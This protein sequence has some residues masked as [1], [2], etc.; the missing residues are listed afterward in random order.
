MSGTIEDDDPM[1]DYHRSSSTAQPTGGG[2]DPM[3]PTPGPPK[4]VTETSW[5]SLPSKD[6]VGKAVEETGH[7]FGVGVRDVVQGRI[8]GLADL[9]TSPFRGA[10]NYVSPGAAT[11]PSEL[12]DKAGGLLPPWLYSKPQ[13]ER[14]KAISPI[15]QA[16]ASMIPL[17]PP[18]ARGPAPGPQAPPSLVNRT[19]IAPTGNASL[20]RAAGTV[21]AAGAG[22]AAG[23]VA[24][25]AIPE[26]SPW[27]VLKPLARLGGNVIGA[28]LANVSM[29]GIERV[30]NSALGKLNATAQA[31]ND[32]NIKPP[33]VGT[34]TG[35]PGV[36][37]L[38]VTASQVPG[39][40]GRMRGGMQETLD[41]FGNRIDEG[42][43]SLHFDATGRSGV[44]P[45]ASQTGEVVQD[46]IRNWRWNDQ[47]PHSF[48]SQE[49]KLFAPVDSRMGH[50]TVDLSGYR[51]ALSS[52]ALDA[53][54]RGLPATQ[55]A[56]AR[57]QLQTLLEALETDRPGASPT[58]RWE[59]AQALRR[60]IGDMR[61]TPEFQQGI[62]DAALSRIYAGIA[63]DM[64]AAATNNGVGRLYK[65]ANQ[66]ATEGHN[67]INRTAS[68]AVET[69]NPRQDIG[70]SQATD[71]LLDS[72]GDDIAQLRRHVPEAAD[73]LAAYK[74]RSMANAKPGQAT[75]PGETSA[76][77]FQTNLIKLKDE[78]PAAFTALFGHNPQI[79]KMIEDLG[80]VSSSLR[81]GG[82]MAN[83]SKTAVSSYLLSLLA[84]GAGGA[85]G[86]LLTGHPLVAA[87]TA[88]AGVA[89]PFAA[90]Q[91]LTNPG[92]IRLMSGQSGPRPVRP[93]VP[94]VL[95]AIPGVT[96]DINDIPSITVR[97][98]R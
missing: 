67:F 17:G 63:G 89:A 22:G 30:A 64:D 95:G 19:L 93:L 94:G 96:G 78:D 57:K 3:L 92:L 47:D 41:K 59:Q 36:Q 79:L 1:G 15:T 11:P 44:V 65:E 72:Y 73:A 71:R 13:T 52:G 16:G 8:G 49:A 50:A 42:A 87:G 43:A 53:E 58:V 74:L 62:G 69:N 34:V 32:L 25:N 31:Y 38:E 24:E 26:N 97:P 54:L 28:G 55:Q 37:N 7:S 27:S 35:S 51:Q 14:E 6:A 45:N 91:V 5:F 68:K 75:G 23:E 86:Q 18:G 39:S 77:T 84:G 90:G 98:N 80:K 10:I 56:L 46:R 4:K 83:T 9:V 33:T 88:A 40:Q 21:A 2:E 60:R 61:G 81:I 48:V 70:P 76:N 82:Q 12:I 85:G 29:S 20:P 66:Y